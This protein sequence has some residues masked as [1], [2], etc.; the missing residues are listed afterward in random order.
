MLHLLVEMSLLKK[1]CIKAGSF[2]GGVRRMFA[3]GLHK[4]DSGGTDSRQRTSC[5]CIIAWRLAAFVLAAA[6]AF[7]LV[8][9]LMLIF[10]M[11]ESRPKFLQTG[12]DL[13]EFGA[14]GNWS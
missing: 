5:G 14:V 11:P 1:A 10:L 12:K 6:I 7:G 9:A 2:F 8:V 4:P 3:V 13:R